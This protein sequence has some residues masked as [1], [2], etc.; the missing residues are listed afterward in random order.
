M[1]KERNQRGYHP[2][3][4]DTEDF[5]YQTMLLWA[6][7]TENPLIAPKRKAATHKKQVR[8]PSRPTPTVQYQRHNIQQMSLIF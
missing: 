1:A 2:V 4:Y 3:S 7:I 8:S 5:L 6:C